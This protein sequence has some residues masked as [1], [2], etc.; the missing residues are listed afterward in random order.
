ML[1]DIKE[2]YKPMN[3]RKFSIS[4]E[5]VKSCYKQNAIP[6]SSFVVQNL[7]RDD[8]YAILNKVIST[9]HSNALCDSLPYIDI[10][11]KEICFA[12]NA[13]SDKQFA[14]LLNSIMED[15]KLYMNL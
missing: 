13:L 4:K 9:E 1:E 6:I 7:F 10:D 15:K 12:N 8:L 2:V 11:M 5:F 14:Q 3:E